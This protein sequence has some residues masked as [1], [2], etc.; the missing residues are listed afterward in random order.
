MYQGSSLFLSWPVGLE[1]GGRWSRTIRH[2]VQTTR[3][4]AAEEADA[5]DADGTAQTAAMA[6]ALAMA[7]ESSGS[8]IRQPAACAPRAD[9]VQLL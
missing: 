8:E 1:P 6:G 9:E 3:D 4:R 5:E 2:V 7:G